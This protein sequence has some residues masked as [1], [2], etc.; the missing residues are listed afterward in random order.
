MPNFRNE[1]MPRT[2]LVDLSDAVLYR[3]TSAATN[4]PRAM[5]TELRFDRE[6]KQTISQAYSDQNHLKYC[7]TARKCG[8]LISNCHTAATKQLSLLFVTPTKP[9]VVVCKAGTLS[10]SD[11]VSES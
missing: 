10:D 9:E 6:L 5:L 2:T 7:M 3:V 11:P 4:D 1:S 8:S